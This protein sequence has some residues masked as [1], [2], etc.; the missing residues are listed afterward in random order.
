MTTEI[1]PIIS[2]S[3][4]SVEDLSVS[5][6]NG[7]TIGESIAI[8][9]KNKTTAKTIAFVGDLI[10]TISLG[11]AAG[12]IFGTITSISF[13]AIVVGFIATKIPLTI[14][15]VKVSNKAMEQLKALS[16]KGHE[17]L[18]SKDDATIGLGI[19]L[20]DAIVSQ[21]DSEACKPLAEYYESK[22]LN[23]KASHYWSFIPLEASN[24]DRNLLDISEVT[25]QYISR[26]EYTC[27]K[28]FLQELIESPP[29]LQ[30]LEVQA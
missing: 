6:G 9:N 8:F 28:R 30:P 1:Q 27:R 24:R 14:I 3:P 22:G 26:I 16:S 7:K 11:L 12:V 21:G 4:F 15:A 25:Q 17:C 19:K 2:R 18:N 10:R 29:K 5:L 23:K 20:L 13:S